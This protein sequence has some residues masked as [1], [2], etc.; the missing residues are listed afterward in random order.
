MKP[1]TNRKLVILGCGNLAWHLASHFRIKKYSV[2][3]YNRRASAKLQGFK[4]KL[5]CAVF[6]DLNSIESDAAVY[7]IAVADKG[8]AAVCRK[9]PILGPDSLVLHSSGSQPLE[10][11]KHT[12]ASS[13]VLYPLQSF[14]AGA[15]LY[16]KEIPL[17][18]QAKDTRSAKLLNAFLL[19]FPGPKLKT[20][21]RLRLLFH[22][23]AV[24]VNNFSNALY[25][26]AYKMLGCDK[27]KFA[28]LMPLARQGLLKLDQLN[29]LEAQTGPARRDD[30]IVMRA[31]LGLLQDHK[32]MR[33]IYRNLSKLIQDQHKIAHA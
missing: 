4:S 18:I 17:L 25:A 26:E 23:C 3:V 6:S 22:L 20:D 32:D 7:L 29:P 9:L 27:N 15:A 10:L 13:G 30:R 2:S 16:W 12:G 28:L 33:V 1:K 5:G 21:N 19:A 8:I 11:L 31:H 14:T 24:L